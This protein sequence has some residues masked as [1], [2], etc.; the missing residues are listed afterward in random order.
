MEGVKKTF[1]S[2]NISEYTLNYVIIDKMM[3]IYIYIY[4]NSQSLTFFENSIM[5]NFVIPLLVIIIC[6]LSMT[7]KE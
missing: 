1:L 5:T 6:H 2:C 3:F 4:I 7:L